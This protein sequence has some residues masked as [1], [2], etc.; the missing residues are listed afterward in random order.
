MER[1]RIR[2]EAGGY[3]FREHDDVGMHALRAAESDHGVEQGCAETNAFYRDVVEQAAVRQDAE[4]KHLKA[5]LK[6]D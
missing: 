1:P 5:T 3:C 6:Y 2:D 4:L